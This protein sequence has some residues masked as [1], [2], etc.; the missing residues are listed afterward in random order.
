MTFISL[1]AAVLILCAICY[2]IMKIPLPEGSP[3]FIR[4]VLYILVAIACIGFLMSWGGFG[5]IEN[6]HIPHR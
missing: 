6:L 1:I 5:G 3:P 2:I 4:N